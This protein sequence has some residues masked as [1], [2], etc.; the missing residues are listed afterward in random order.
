MQTNFSNQFFNKYAR[1]T[2]FIF[3]FFIFLIID[4]LGTFAFNRLY[5]KD[6]KERVHEKLG[7]QDSIISH[8]FKPNGE[9]YSKSYNVFTNSLGF[10]DYAIREIDLNRD[11]RLL[12]M[13][14]SFTEGVWLSWENTFPG[15]I[16]DSLIKFDI[17]VLNA[18]V[19]SYS[20]FIHWKKLEYLIKDVGL[21]LNNLVVFI[22]ISDIS[23]E[24]DY[25]GKYEKNSS[26]LIENEIKNSRQS[27][28]ILVNEIED[29]KTKI[30][31][32]L[33]YN[34][35]FFYNLSDL[36]YD[37]IMSSSIHKTSLMEKINKVPWWMDKNHFHSN[38]P[39]K[40]RDNWQGKI[41]HGQSLME[42]S[43]DNI[44]A[45]C[46][47]ENIDVTIAV[48]PWPNSIMFNDFYSE[49]IKNWNLYCKNKNI[50]FL[51]LY[52]LFFEPNMSK[53]EREKIIYSNYILRDF[54]FNEVGHRKIANEYIKH[55]ND[56][57]AFD[58]D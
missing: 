38:W 48:Y 25:R 1:T 40:T 51:N 2:L 17:E 57:N 3:V 18:G 41:D 15:M 33:K 39:L 44:I 45:I 30:F 56:L 22:D 9:Y 12:I 34:F 14:D 49:H 23:N 11:K 24:I 54:H 50:K 7:V 52:P 5:P 29:L 16:A 53:S 31:T 26:F 27:N 55:F 10:K 47:K 35:I 13:G 28:N 43:M 36:I 58:L 42:E 32:L 20:P 37:L 6:W 19:A 21:R 8:T 4:F 46:T